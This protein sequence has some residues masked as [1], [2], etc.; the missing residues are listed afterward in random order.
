MLRSLIILP[1][2]VLLI[3][4][5]KAFFN[6]VYQSTASGAFLSNTI[7]ARKQSEVALQML[8]HLAGTSLW[9]DVDRPNDE[10]NADK[11][12]SLPAK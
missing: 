5:G 9:I 3:S 8:G 2:G 10:M 4:C 11:Y 12:F 6:K 1:T 7:K